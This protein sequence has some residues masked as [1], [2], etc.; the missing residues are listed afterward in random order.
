MQNEFM[1]DNTV[2]NEKNVKEAIPSN[3]KEMTILQLMESIT[4]KAAHSR[5]SDCFFAKV[6]PLST[7]LGEKLGLTPEQ[8]VLYSI[9]IDNYNDS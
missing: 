4:E 7:L 8:A 9:F 3:Y 1:F 2:R 6:R 5:L